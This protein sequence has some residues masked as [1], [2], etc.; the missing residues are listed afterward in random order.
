VSE[1]ASITLLEAMASGLPAVVTAVGGNPELVRDGIDGILVPRG[2]AASFTAAF[3][4]LIDDA[5][6]RGRMGRS[7]A[8]RVRSHFQMAATIERYWTLYNS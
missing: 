2:D 6:T 7:G 5:D 3:L 4:R 8:E 1:A